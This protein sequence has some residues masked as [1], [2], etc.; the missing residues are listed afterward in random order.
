MTVLLLMIV[1]ALVVK[2]LVSPTQDPRLGAIRRAGFPVTLAELNTYYPTVP[3]QENAALVFNQAFEL[4]LFTNS[5]FEGFFSKD[6]G[7]ARG[8]PLPEEFQNDLRLVLATN[9]AAV[10]LLYAATNFSHSRYPLDLRDGFMV[11]LPHLARIKRA[12]TL[13][14]LEGLSHASAGESNQAFSAFSAGLHATESLRE[15]PILISY[16]VEIACCAMVARRLE[17]SLN[18]TGFDESQLFCLQQQFAAAEDQR[19]I[20]RALAGERAFG[21]SFFIDRHIQ[22]SVMAQQKGFSLP[23]GLAGQVAITVYRASGLMGKDQDFYVDTMGKSIA[24]AEL[25]AHQRVKAG[26]GPSMVTSNRWLLISR[27][28]LPALAQALDRA[29]QHSARMRVVETALGVERFRLAHSGALPDALEQLVPQFLPAVRV[30]PYEG[31]PLR[32]KKLDRG[33]VVYSIGPD[34]KDDGGAEPAAQGN[35]AKGTRATPADI[36]FVVERE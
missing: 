10:R 28:M 27:L 7:V 2:N 30:D 31:K 14:S 3:D 5:I 32:Y 22:R 20:A 36:T 25:P 26:P 8:K 17:Q 23:A 11:L 33:Y 35:A 16:L 15:E 6:P 1:A 12:A 24:M 29:T 19:G 34:Q 21:L 13:L 9:A 4:D 18:L